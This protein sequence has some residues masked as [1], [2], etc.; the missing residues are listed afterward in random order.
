M[1]DNKA[2]DRVFVTLRDA[3]ICRDRVFTNDVEYIRA[4]L[5]P[6]WQPIETVRDAGDGFAL[7]Y[8]EDFDPCVIQV[9]LCDSLI[10]DFGALSNSYN[11]THWMPLPKAPS[12]E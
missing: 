12:C 10:D 2:P 5:V 8:D 9:F 11:P 4:D 1:N 3:N 7:I 6:Q